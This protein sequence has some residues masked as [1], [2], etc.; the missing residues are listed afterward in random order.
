MQ[1]LVWPAKN[2]S[3]EARAVFWYAGSDLITNKSKD[4]ELAKTNKARNNKSN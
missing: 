4:S 3:T 1:L 2:S